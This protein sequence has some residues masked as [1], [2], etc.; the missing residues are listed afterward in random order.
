MTPSPPCDPS[1]EQEQEPTAP[2]QQQRLDALL[3]ELSSLSQELANQ[4]EALVNLLRQLEQL[5]RQI[6]DGPL[7]G[8]LP[9]DRHRLF[10]LLQNLEQ[11]GGWPYIPRPQLHNFLR[12]L[13]QQPP[14]APE[15]LDTPEHQPPREL[16]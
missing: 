2:G 7:R 9:T 10:A 5:H 12:Q 8:S 11:S 3:A 14:E 6:Q 13:Q 1:T 16:K 15:T 4:P